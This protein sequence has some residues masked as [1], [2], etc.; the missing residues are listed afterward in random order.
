MTIAALSSPMA[1]IPSMRTPEGKEGPGP[2][3][4]GDAD[5]KGIGAS[6]SA[7]SRAAVPPGMGSAVNT[8]A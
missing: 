2:D 1:A 3:H 8:Q 4:D 7:V 5:D 6:T